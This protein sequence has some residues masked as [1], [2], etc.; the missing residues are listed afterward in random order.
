[1]NDIFNENVPLKTETPAFAKHVLPAVPLSEVYLEDC[2]KALKRYADNHFDLAIVDPPYGINASMGVGLHSR[3]KFQKAGKQWDSQTPTAEYWQELMR[4]SKNQ[5]VCGANYFME[6]L[7]STKSFVCWIKNNPA[8]NFA[9]A[10]YLWTSFDINGKVYDSKKQIQHQIMWE[11]GSMHP[12]QKPI[13]LYDWLLNRFA[14]E[15]DLILDTHLGSGS[16]RIAAYKG[17]FNFVGF[18]ID[19]E[20]YEK[21]EKRFNDFKSQLRLF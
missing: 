3:R 17:G 7:Y 10:E 19:Q 5:I 8:P 21:Q 20:Y 1:M 11:G 15:G 14:K 18:E 2:V 4:V 16:S 12:T 6:H 13:A 9:E